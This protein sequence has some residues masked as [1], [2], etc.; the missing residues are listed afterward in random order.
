MTKSDALNSLH[1]TCIRLEV[2]RALKSCKV[3]G[4]LAAYALIKFEQERSEIDTTI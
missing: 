4:G 2:Q 3:V 1:K